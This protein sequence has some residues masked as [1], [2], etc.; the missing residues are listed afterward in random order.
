MPPIP[1]SSPLLPSLMADLPGP[2]PDGH[3]DGWPHCS[4]PAVPLLRSPLRSSLPEPP[5]GPHAH[6]WYAHPTANLSAPIMQATQHPLCIRPCTTQPPSLTP[7]SHM[8]WPH[9]SLLSCLPAAY[10]LAYQSTPYSAACQQPAAL[11]Q[12]TYDA[13]LSHTFSN[14]LSHGLTH[15]LTSPLTSW[16][17]ASLI[18]TI[19]KTIPSADSESHCMYISWHRS[20]PSGSSLC[21]YNFLIPFLP[22]THP[23]L[24]G[25]TPNP[26]DCPR[27]LNNQPLPAAAWYWL[28][29]K[30]S[31]LAKL[32]HFNVVV[33]KQ[34]W[35][36]KEDQQE[37][38]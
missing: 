16:S 21:Q 1:S 9:C 14:P 22:H 3:H 31:Q 35:S 29:P 15:P 32:L 34:S 12:Y 23:R 36:P 25:G 37:V 2:G 13:L 10:Q 30:S 17:Y 11:L 33:P 19:S 7:T 20:D 28:I 24:S 38:Q 5:S 26:E 18:H 27:Y 4:P 8:G 6:P